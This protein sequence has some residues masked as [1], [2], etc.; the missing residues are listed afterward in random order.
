MSLAQ[1]FCSAILEMKPREVVGGMVYVMLLA[2]LI[3]DYLLQT[4]MIV[5]WKMRSLAGVVAHGII[6]TVATMVCAMLVAPS[7]WPY[8]LLIGLI[9]TAIDVVRARIIRTQDPVQEMAWYLIDQVAHL[10]V[11][12]LVVTASGNPTWSELTGVARFLTDPRF[13]L[14]AIS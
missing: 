4:A 1:G 6:V 14:Y 9:H 12:W 10:A 11:I 13:L 3:G 5:R 2:H 8:A 7:W